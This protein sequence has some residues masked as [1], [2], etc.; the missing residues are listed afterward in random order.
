MTFGRD[1]FNSEENL[2]RAIAHHLENSEIIQ[3]FVGDRPEQYE[4]FED[5]DQTT[6]TVHVDSLKIEDDGDD[7]T[8]SYTAA[9]EVRRALAGQD[10]RG[11]ETVYTTEVV[12]GQV[13]GSVTITV[14]EPDIDDLNDPYYE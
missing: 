2:R 9:V 3:D 14:G 1:A 5:Q 8:A 7:A 12:N 6:V 10:A 11:D 4:T 13:S